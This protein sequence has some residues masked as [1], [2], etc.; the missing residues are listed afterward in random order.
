MY[1]THNSH[2]TFGWT[3]LIN[4]VGRL[5]TS[6]GA[7][8]PGKSLVIDFETTYCITL[9]ARWNAAMDLLKEKGK[10]TDKTDNPKIS[11]MKNIVHTQSIYR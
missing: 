7:E 2:L 5:D 1:L 11:A 8:E 4:P 9:A 6:T 3:G 10:V